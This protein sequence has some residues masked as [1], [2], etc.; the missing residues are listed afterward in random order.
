MNEV[1]GQTFFELK[2]EIVNRFFNIKENI[3]KSSIYG[4]EKYDV[5]STIINEDDLKIFE[6]HFSPVLKEDLLKEDLLEKIKFSDEDMFVE[7]IFINESIDIIEYLNN[8]EIRG[9]IITDKGVF[10]ALFQ[11]RKNEKY[12]KKIQELYKITERNKIDWQIPN[13]PYSGKYMEVYLKSYDEALL[14][15]EFIK[16][17][18]YET[19]ASYLKGLIF[20]WNIKEREVEYEEF[21]KPTE[22]QLTYEYLVNV[23]Y[24]KKYLVNLETGE[25]MIS[26]IA[27]EESI[28]FITDQKTNGRL[29]LWEI[30]E[31]TEEGLEE[32]LIH[33]VYSNKTTFP[34]KKE[35]FYH[36]EDFM[37]LVDS[38]SDI[39][40]IKLEDIL[41]DKENNELLKIIDY[42]FFL[43]EEF[44]IKNKREN[45]YLKLE[46]KE[47]IFSNEIISYIVSIL[48]MKNKDFKFAVLK[49]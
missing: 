44:E 20:C 17:I 35:I 47:N 33:K 2:S 29:K 13:L 4:F 43:K 25:L 10:P 16:D 11:I 45:A 6:N 14:D 40:G 38:L 23:P 31:E 3:F 18:K 15:S 46:Y 28:I 26:Y 49:S 12:L 9:K 1:M 30:L 42:N 7:N 41:L 8:T 39:Q 36:K 34:N 32:Y 24:N 22:E 37:A 19:E 5:Y 21:V 27:D 48:N